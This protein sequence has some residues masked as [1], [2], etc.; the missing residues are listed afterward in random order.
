MIEELVLRAET[1]FKKY[2]SI[3]TGEG[4]TRKELRLLERRGLVE[5]QMMQ[6]K[7]TGALINQ[8]KPVSL[9]AELIGKKNKNT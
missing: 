1:I 7:K 8:W 2:G 3:V 4:M 6:N 9:A 5:R